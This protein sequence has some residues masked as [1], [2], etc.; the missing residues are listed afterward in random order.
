MNL[1]HLRY[2]ETI[3]R[4][5][6]YGKAAQLLH[7]TQPNLSHAISQLE[8]EL[9]VPL[10]EKSGRNVHLTRYGNIFLDSVSHVLEHL[11]STVRSLQEIKNGGG[12]IVLGCIRNL[13]ADLIPHLMQE[14]LQTPQGQN[15]T[16][17]LHTGSSFS[18]ILLEHAE[19]GDY[20]M[21]F[22]SHAGVPTQMDF[23]FLS[24]VSFCHRSAPSSSTGT[25]G[26]CKFNPDDFLSSHFSFKTKR[27]S[28]CH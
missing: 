23:F 7:V 25:N 21:V 4:L 13:G 19:N 24:T 18:S 26:L 14:F 28:L 1:D 16:F 12:M 6:H 3:A 20:D 8:S 15:V 5:E 10:F 11:D 2:F 17:Q 9:G 27:S 22:T